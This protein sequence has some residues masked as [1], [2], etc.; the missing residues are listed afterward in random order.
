VKIISGLEVEFVWG[1]A[2]ELLI[3]QPLIQ[4][5]IQSIHTISTTPLQ[6][7][8]DAQERFDT[9]RLD[10]MVQLEQTKLQLAQLQAENRRLLS[11]PQDESNDPP[12]RQ[13]VNG[14]VAGKNSR[15]THSEN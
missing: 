9:K 14:N 1:D 7:A 12:V 2:Q 4:Q 8:C 5:T 3:L 11:A 13:Q 10:A 15:R 6:L